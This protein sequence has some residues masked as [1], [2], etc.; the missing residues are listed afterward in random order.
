MNKKKKIT[1]VTGGRI[2]IYFSLIIVR[3]NILCEFITSHLKNDV[4]NYKIKKKNLLT[5]IDHVLLEDP[6]TYYDK[7]FFII[8]IINFH[9]FPSL[10]FSVNT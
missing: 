6:T 9:I 2:F 3:R 7:L 1:I 5:A 10:F 8:I 4:F